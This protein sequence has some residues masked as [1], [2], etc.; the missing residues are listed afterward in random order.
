MIADKIK[1]EERHCYKIFTRGGDGKQNR[2]HGNG[3]WSCCCRE[4]KREKRGEG[5][6]CEKRETK[7]MVNV[8]TS[9]Y[10]LNRL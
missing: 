6:R 4:M 2:S 9:W 3:W 8:F 5:M 10:M 7:E 1:C